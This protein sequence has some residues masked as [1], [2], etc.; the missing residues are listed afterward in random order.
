MHVPKEDGLSLR[1]G[2]ASEWKEPSTFQC[3]PLPGPRKKSTVKRVG[4]TQERKDKEAAAAAVV[5]SQITP[6]PITEEIVDTS[7][8]TKDFFEVKF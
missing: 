3:N 2:K 6:A 7:D 4:V 8:F 1:P 5:L